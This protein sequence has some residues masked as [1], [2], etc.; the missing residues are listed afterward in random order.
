MVL[1]DA[2]LAQDAGRRVVLGVELLLLH[3]LGQHGLLVGLVVDAEARRDAGPG[4]EFAQEPD[5]Q[6]VEGADRGAR[7]ARP[8]S[9]GGCASPRPPCW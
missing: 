1:E 3:H 7:R 4:G 5:A 9:A 6:A 8:W 2:D